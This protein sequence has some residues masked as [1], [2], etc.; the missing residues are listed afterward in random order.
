MVNFKEL[1]TRQKKA[2]MNI[3]YAANEYIGGLENTLQDFDEDSQ[4]Y[5]DAYKILHNHEGLVET[6][7][8]IAITC[9]CARGSY[10]HSESF[11]KDIRFCGKEFLTQLVEEEVVKEGY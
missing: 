4:E 3:K 6:I 7:Y 2:F 9:I 5:K 1:N 11:I 10:T 8:N